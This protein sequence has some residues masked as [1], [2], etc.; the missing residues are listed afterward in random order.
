MPDDK[1][2]KR[3]RYTK[4][5]RQ[6]TSPCKGPEVRTSFACRRKDGRKECYELRLEG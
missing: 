1:E 4:L 5:P 6:S 2:E 3:W